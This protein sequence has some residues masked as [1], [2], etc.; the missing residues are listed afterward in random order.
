MD[1]IK[2]ALVGC[3][4]IGQVVHLPILQRMPDVEVVAIVDTDKRM[5]QAV[6]ERAGVANYFKS[7]DELFKSGVGDEVAAVDICS[8]TDSHRE[9]AIAA[10]QSGKDILI[11]KPIARTAKEAKDI[12]DCGHKYGQKVMVGMNNRFRPDTMILKSFIE[13]EEL[14][15]L[16]FIKSGWL[17]QQS[18]T[19]AWQ[20]QKERSGGG[21]FLDLG[22]V[23]LD[24]ALWLLNYPAV[25]SVSATTYHQK[26]K[27]VE[28]SAALFAR[29][30]ND[31][32]LT[33]E[34]SWTFHR[35]ADFFYCNVFGDEGSAFIN[36]LKVFKRVQGNLVNLTPAKPQTPVSLYKRSYEN[37]LRHWINAVK[38]VVPLM[39][40]GD[41]AALR[42]NVVEAIYQSAAKK[43]EIT[44]GKETTKP[45]RAK[46]A[47]K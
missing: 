34:V 1:K 39:S 23:M 7:I 3:G 22:I 29:L 25:L 44:L 4:N 30:A 8:P 14:G 20:S 13:N 38:G 10:L 15:K 28:D 47:K 18:S 40:T 5:A 12:V 2:V 6:A 37:E 43:K 11:E 45:A 33:L 26:T 24:M 19:S 41:E 32:T 17:K 16:F 46:A 36:P 42:M 21:V 27:A 31:V 35:D 9:A